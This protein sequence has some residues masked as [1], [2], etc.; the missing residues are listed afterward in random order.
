MRASIVVFLLLLGLPTAAEVLS[1]KPGERSVTVKGELT[2]DQ[3]REY[4]FHGQAGQRF[5]FQANA[6]RGEHLV[7]HIR[8]A[9]KRD[10]FTNFQSGTLEG[11]G[12]LPVSGDYTMF[13]ALRRAE[14][15]REG[16]LRYGLT[17]T[18]H[19]QDQVVALQGGGQYF[20]NDEQG[21][22]AVQ[23]V[24]VKLAGDHQAEIYVSFGEQ[25]GFVIHATWKEHLDESALLQVQSAFGQPATGRGVVL[26]DDDSDDDGKPAMVFLTFESPSQGSFH[27][28]EYGR[29]SK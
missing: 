2:A 25:D 8:D 3:T 26:L 24:S 15:Q 22:R 20:V 5:D 16:H 27:L 28:L 1:F 19:P 18:L 23:G 21:V 11:R 13:L 12:V 4:I 17:L 7:V 9:A 6:S 14:A 29:P 10:V